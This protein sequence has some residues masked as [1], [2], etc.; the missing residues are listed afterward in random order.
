M[1]PIIE[2]PR[3]TRQIAVERLE[4]LA[5]QQHL[6]AGQAE[7]LLKYLQETPFDQFR[8]WVGEKA[9]ALLRERASPPIKARIWGLCD[10]ADDRQLYFLLLALMNEKKD[11]PRLERHVVRG[12]N[13]DDTTLRALA[14]ELVWNQS[15]TVARAVLAKRKAAVIRKLLA[16]GR[17]MSV[18]EVIAMLGVKGVKI[19]ISQVDTVKGSLKQKKRKEIRKSLD[20]TEVSDDA[21]LI[22]KVRKL[23]RETGG[24]SKL[25]QLVDDLSKRGH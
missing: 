8:Y 24:M 19:L 9:A 4:A 3:D 1:V 21:Q 5:G 6:S 15:P 12:L 2:I 17:E 14:S 23:A 13:S 22:S 10:A 20:K 16:Q 18:I 25:K 11:W 7:E